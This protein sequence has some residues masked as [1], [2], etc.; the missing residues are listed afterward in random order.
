MTDRE[1][2]TELLGI[3][4]W[5]VVVLYLVNSVI[6]CQRTEI[7]YKY[8]IEQLKVQRGVSK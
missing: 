4:F 3:M 8:R 1:K 5:L 6:G 2:F 7:E